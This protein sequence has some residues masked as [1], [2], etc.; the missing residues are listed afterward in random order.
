MHRPRLGAIAAEASA[1]A[2]RSDSWAVFRRALRSR[3]VLAAAAASWALNFGFYMLL[4]GT[5][6]LGCGNIFLFAVPLSTKEIQ[7]MLHNYCTSSSI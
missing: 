2:A 6:A 3:A 5:L 1:P 7:R 4:N